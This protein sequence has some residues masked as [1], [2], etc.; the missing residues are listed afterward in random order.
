MNLRAISR[1]KLFAFFGILL[2]SVSLIYFYLIY[3]QENYASIKQSGDRCQSELTSIKYQLNAVT[4]YKDR[5]DKQLTEAQKKFDLDRARFK[6][7]ME[8]CVAMKQQTTL[9]ETQFE[10]LQTECRRIKEEFD[11]LGKNLGTKKV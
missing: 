8:S 9:C 2:C 7:I 1:E 4:E 11:E 10:D 5:L 3:V 6:D